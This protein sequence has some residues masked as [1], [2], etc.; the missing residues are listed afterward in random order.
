VAGLIHQ[1]GDAAPTWWQKGRSRV[2]G[3]ASVGRLTRRRAEPD[4]K[5]AVEERQDPE[6][7]TR[8]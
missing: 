1:V 4:A 2:T 5:A 7:E 8:H 3:W 6:E